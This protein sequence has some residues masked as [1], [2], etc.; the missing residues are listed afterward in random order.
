MQRDFGARKGA[1]DSEN[2]MGCPWSK[3]ELLPEIEAVRKNAQMDHGSQ[4]Q[5]ATS[6]GARI[7]NEVEEQVTDCR[8]VE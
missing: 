3:K 1:K 7:A 2:G 4:V 6:D 8:I 5:N